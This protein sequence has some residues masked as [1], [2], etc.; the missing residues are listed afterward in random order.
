MMS[1]KT[2]TSTPNTA[3]SLK[4]PTPEPHSPVTPFFLPPEHQTST[5]IIR[6]FDLITPGNDKVKHT[7]KPAAAKA[8]FDDDLMA[9][10]RCLRLVPY[11]MIEAGGK[12][13]VYGQT[14]FKQVFDVG[15]AKSTGVTE[16]HGIRGRCFF[17][18]RRYCQCLES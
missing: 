4:T 9:S 15:P 11:A 12:V 18:I 2:L 7:S 17:T 1:I 13:E 3:D 6:S 16:K 10:H 8:R 5:H 14:G